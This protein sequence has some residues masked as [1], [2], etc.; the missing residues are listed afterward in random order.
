MTNREF[1]SILDTEDLA[2]TL[3]HNDIFN[4][5]KFSPLFTNTEFNEQDFVALKERL[6]EWLNA[7]V[8]NS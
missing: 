1:L 5:L 4:A 6:I 8:E 3:I 2:D 7:E